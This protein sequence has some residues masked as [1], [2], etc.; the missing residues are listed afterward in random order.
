MRR[1]PVRVVAG[2]VALERTGRE[3]HTGAVM[4]V[5]RHRVRPGSASGFRSDARAALSVLATR[6]GF[7]R[8]SVA[9]AVDD[10][11]LWT[12]VT[13][14]RDVGS[15]RRALT[16]YEAK[17]IV[18]PLLSTALDEPSAFEVLDAVGGE[19]GGVEVA[20]GSDLAVDAGQTRL[21]EAAAPFVASDLDA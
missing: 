19:A 16:G 8:G 5:T 17:M 2:A 12:V 1:S 11:E 4:V 7:L 21:G 13:S 10:A 15:Y 20:G 18:V 6:P 3:A 14:W 9:R